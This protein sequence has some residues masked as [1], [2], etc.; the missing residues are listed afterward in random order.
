MGYLQRFQS[1]R[2]TVRRLAR[3]A[4]GMALSVPLLLGACGPQQAPSG[5]GQSIPSP[6]YVIGPLDTLHVFVWHNPDLTEVVTV[7]PD[8]RISVP[9]IN[10]MP[11]AGITPSQLAHNIQEKLKNY[12]QDPIVT[13]MVTSF[14]GPYSGQVRIVGEAAHPQAIPYRA[15]MTLLDAMIQAGGLTQ[16]AA[17]N[18]GTLVRTVN[19][20]ETEYRVRIGDLILDGDMTA[21]V[22]L[23]PGDIVIIPQSWF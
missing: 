20:K 1:H 11:A 6:D 18:R 12:I 9:L 7:R 13:V 8:G 19:G 5:L 2:V 10:D 3:L 17:G 22:P 14:T 16:Y 15:Q 4:L 23:L 21:N